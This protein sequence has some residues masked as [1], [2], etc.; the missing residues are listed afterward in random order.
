MVHDVVVV[1]GGLEGD[2]VVGLVI[3][4]V[5]HKTSVGRLGRRHFGSGKPELQASDTCKLIDVGRI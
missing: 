4:N 1:D 2:E 3:R 5:E